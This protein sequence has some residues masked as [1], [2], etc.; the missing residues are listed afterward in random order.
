MRTLQRIGRGYGQD[1][2]SPMAI[3]G[4][5]EAR[6]LSTGWDGLA[7]APLRPRHADGQ[8]GGDAEQAE[9]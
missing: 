7:P 6:A 9:P 8:D 4:V 5:A 3:P 2:P 1:D